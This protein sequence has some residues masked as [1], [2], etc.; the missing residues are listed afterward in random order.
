LEATFIY[1][2]HEGV[3]I[4]CSRYRVLTPAKYLQRAGHQINVQSNPGIQTLYADRKI[5]VAAGI[6]FTKISETVLIERNIIPDWM[7]MLRLSG[8]KKIVVTFDDNY[9]LMQNYALAKPWWDKHYPLFLKALGMADLVIVPSHA[10]VSYYKQYCKKIEYVANYIDDELWKDAT[11][12]GD[13]KI[14]GWGGSSQH[15][16][17]WQQKRMSSALAQILRE[18]PDWELHMVADNLPDIIKGFPKGV[19]IKWHS[20]MSHTNWPGVMSSFS[21][22]LAPLYGEYDRY[23]S[24]LKLVEYGLGRV[25]WIASWMDPYTK[26]HVRGGV[27]TKESGWYD[28]L[29]LMVKDE[30]ARKNLSEAGREWAEGYFMSRNVG[31]YEQLL[32]S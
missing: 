18:N 27:L 2:D 1:A 15:V 29:S 25:P 20:W 13:K 6:D 5:S 4:N 19:E 24:N 3:E 8:A 9:A 21:I 10:L 31:V 26:T 23:R 7:D 17:S 11:E 28:S 32:W 30:K 12:R 16:E 14:I 22:G